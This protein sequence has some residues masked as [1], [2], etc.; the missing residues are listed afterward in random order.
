MKKLT[1]KRKT[2]LIIILTLLFGFFLGVFVSGFYIRK[3]FREFI[4]V[5]NER[6]FK[7]R[8]IKVLDLS[9]K[10]TIV[11]DSVITKHALVIE[12]LHNNFQKGFKQNMDSLENEMQPYLT[13][14]Q[15]QIIIEI[16]ERHRKFR[17]PFLFR[18]MK[19]RDKRHKMKKMHK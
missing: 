18:K 1:Q 11:L 17:K 6:G 13:K 4:S 7:H 15:K 10:Q 16:K 9:D 3:E 2:I 8:M 19:N 12:K 14:A 5:K